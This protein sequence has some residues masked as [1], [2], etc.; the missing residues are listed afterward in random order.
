MYDDVRGMIIGSHSYSYCQTLKKIEGT[1]IYNNPCE[2]ERSKIHLLKY[3]NNRKNYL[4]RFTGEEYIHLLA[5]DCFYQVPSALKNLNNGGSKIIA[6]LHHYPTKFFSRRI[7]K[8]C[9]KYITYIVVHSEYIKMKLNE[10]GIEN[11]VVINY[12]AFV[13]N[14]ILPQKTNESGYFEFLCLGGTRFSKGA[15]ILAD[16]FG[17]FDPE[18]KDK[19]KFTFAGKEV[20]VK[21]SYIENRAKLFQIN[22]SIVNRVISDEEYWKYI[23]DTDCL[24][25]PYRKKFSGASGPMTDGVYAQKLVIGPANGNLGYLIVNNKLGVTFE[26]ENPSSLADAIK[27]VVLNDIKWT[28]RA[29]EYRSSLDTKIFLEEYKKLYSRLLNQ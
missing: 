13:N 19:I 26:T 11:V 5:L 23:Y 16:A 15:D 28:Q 22:L 12:P 20:D 7:L 3:I 25:L 24:I 2:F 10:I 4:A 1:C 27:R 8:T 21:Y 14:E 17:Y 29:E 6:T 9:S 18:V